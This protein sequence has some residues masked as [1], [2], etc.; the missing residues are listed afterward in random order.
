MILA[1]KGCQGVFMNKKIFE[2]LCKIIVEI[3]DC[4]QENF[5]NF[6]TIL[7]SFG[8][9]GYETFKQNL[10]R[11]ILHNIR[12]HHAQSDESINWKFLAI[13]LELN[14]ANNQIYENYTFY[15]DILWQSVID[16]LKSKNTWQDRIRNVI[17][18]EMKHVNVKFHFW[19]EVRSTNWQ[20][21]FLMEQDKLIVL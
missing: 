16:E 13:Y 5:A 3:A 18:K 6:T 11:Q 10:A 2:G 12:L 14:T 7:A 15:K 20:H 1:E 21:T 19:L 9:K 4:E 8:T 17:V